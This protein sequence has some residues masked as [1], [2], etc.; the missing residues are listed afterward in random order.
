MPGGHRY[1]F[2]TNLLNISLFQL[3]FHT[4]GIAF[5]TTLYRHD[6][7]Q[8]QIEKHGST[9]ANQRKHNPKKAYKT[10]IPTEIVGDTGTHTG[11]LAI[12]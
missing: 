9:H 11:N 5:T 6:K 12:F 10:Y 4:L 3:L 8:Y 1:S 2:Y 7:S